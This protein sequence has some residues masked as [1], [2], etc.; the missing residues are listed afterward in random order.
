MPGEGLILD[1]WKE[2]QPTLVKELRAK[3]DLDRVVKELAELVSEVHGGLIGQGL[4]WYQADELVRPMWQLPDEET[5]PVATE[6]ILLGH[7]PL[8]IN[9]RRF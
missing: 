3:G 2:F 7:K 1:H 9:Q 8:P 5:E 4:D 6:G